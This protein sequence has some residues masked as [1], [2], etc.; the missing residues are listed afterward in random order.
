MKDARQQG[1]RRS[2][3]AGRG[4]TFVELMIAIAV[5][6]LVSMLIYSAFSGLA[7]SK[8]GITRINDRYRE[9]RG[10]VQ[11]IT[12]DLQSAY[13]SL[14]K[15]IDLTIQ[16]MSTAFIG[17]GG[18]RAARLDFNS[19]S[20]QQ[21]DKDAHESDQEEVSY[22]DSEDPQNPGVYDLLRRSSYRVDLD[23]EKGGR[24]DVLVTD[25][26]LFE[27]EFLDPTTG[28]WV[29][30]WDTTQA[31]GQLDR[32]PL[33]VRFSLVLNGGQRRG[34]SSARAPIKFDAKVTLPIQRALTFAME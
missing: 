3:A 12:R 17:K 2:V 21:F 29:D 7:T 5:L 20:H 31:T 15:P 1:A 30:N 14:H 28:Q 24:A 34:A 16:V 27:V 26:D 25:I 11:R 23:T 8:E 19:F 18:S 9:G 13:L 33:Q 32:L 4:F 22:F 6:A 10:A